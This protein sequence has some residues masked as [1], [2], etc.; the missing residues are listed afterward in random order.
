M[1]LPTGGQISYAYTGGSS[2]NITCADGSAPGL[3][4]Y[5]PDT[6][7]SFWNYART[8][9]TAAASA[10]LVTDPS[11]QANQSIVQFQYI[12]E[13]Q[14]DDYQ[15]SAPA[16]SSLP[17]SESTLQTSSLLRETQTCYNASSS[18]CTG[19][20]ITLPITQRTG[21]ML[22]PGAAKTSRPSTSTSTTP[23]AR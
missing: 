17:I 9:G 21:T 2:G 6:G 22:W 11:S 8:M 14:R 15:G 5:T 13:T 12:Y 1:T 10:T 20:G 18:P 3:K 23:E 16:F 4:R 7:S 19:T